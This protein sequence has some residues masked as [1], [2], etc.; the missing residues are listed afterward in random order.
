MEILSDFFKLF[1]DFFTDKEVV[2]P[3]IQM[4]YYVAIINIC[5][6]MQRYRLCF[7]VS[8]IFS[9]YWMFALNKE[10]FVS[11]DGT[12]D[13]GGFYVLGGAV[14]VLMISL[15]SFFTQGATQ[16]SG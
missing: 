4:V 11:L 16:E 7:V 5:M 15:I 3:A 13:G 1:C 10:Q 2:I 12:F 14:L 9:F 8:L 6:L